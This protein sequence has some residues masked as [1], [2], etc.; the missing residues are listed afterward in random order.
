MN[1][2]EYEQGGPEFICRIQ[3]D[4]DM[5]VIEMKTTDRA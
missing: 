2:K 1:E 3:K 5:A 4:K